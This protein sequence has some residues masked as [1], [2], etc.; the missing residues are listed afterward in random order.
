MRA[1]LSAFAARLREHDNLNEQTVVIS[2]LPTPAIMPGGGWCV[3]VSPGGGRFGDQSQHTQLTTTARVCV[4][5]FVRKNL[6]RPGRAEA[7]LVSSEGSLLEWQEEILQ[8]LTVADTSKASYSN[9]W[10]PAANGRPLC[11][12][13][14]FPSDYSEPGEVPEHAGWI[15]IHLFFSVSFDWDLYGNG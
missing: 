12:S 2:D 3:A 5:I 4:G 13:I 9:A 6:D 1:I 8:L 7:A 11:R 10:E 14:P 15:G